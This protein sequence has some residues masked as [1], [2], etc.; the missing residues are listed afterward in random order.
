MMKRVFVEIEDGVVVDIH[1]VEV[2]GNRGANAAEPRNPIQSRRPGN[3]L[4]PHQAANKGDR[5]VNGTL[6]RPL[7]KR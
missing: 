7:V 4:R 1:D 2:K 3:E 5:V 6:C